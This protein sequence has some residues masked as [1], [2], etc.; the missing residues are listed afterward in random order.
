[1]KG[2]QC[3]ATN[4]QGRV[5]KDP[6]QDLATST[7]QDEDQGHVTIGGGHGHEMIVEGH[8]LATDERRGLT[9]VIDTGLGQPKSVEINL[10][11]PILHLF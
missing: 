8:D 9:R 2:V 4:A 5:V 11:K 7:A 3:H 1:M 6:D 10:S